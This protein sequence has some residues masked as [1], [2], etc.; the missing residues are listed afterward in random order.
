[1]RLRGRAGGLSGG[2]AADG[3]TGQ[4]ADRRGG[5]G[6]DGGAGAV[7]PGA[8]GTPDAPDAPAPDRPAPDGDGSTAGGAAVGTRERTRERLVADLTERIEA[9]DPVSLGMLRHYRADGPSEPVTAH[10][11]GGGDADREV[12]YA[13]NRRLRRAGL[14]RHAGRGTYEYALSDL[15][16]EEGGGRLRDPDLDAA[17]RAI[18]EAAVLPADER[19]SDGEPSDGS[20]AGGGATASEDAEFVETA[21]GDGGAAFRE[22]DAEFVEEGPSPPA[23]ER[24]DGGTDAGDD[25]DDGDEAVVLRETGPASDGLVDRSED[26]RDAEFVE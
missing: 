23:R 19:G 16:R 22:D 5:D 13:R 6:A 18:E 24:G 8:T 10:L 4:A 3:G 14:V 17:V 11:S 15:V 20:D 9:L 25:G 21:E 2:D 7:E 26:P 12:A 1:R